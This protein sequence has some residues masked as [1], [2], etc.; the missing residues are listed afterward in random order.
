[1]A[2]ATIRIRLTEAQRSALECRDLALN[3]EDALLAT[4]WERGDRRSL[5][6][7]AH[8]GEALFEL[9]NEASNAE[10]AF[11]QD[12]RHDPDLRQFA[13]RAARSLASVASRVLRNA[14][15]Y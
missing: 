1:M 14:R 8:D 12:P 3:P 10:D 5:V 6:F 11:A 13:G 4:A 7:E 2:A 9:L 15:N